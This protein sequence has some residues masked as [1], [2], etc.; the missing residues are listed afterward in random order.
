MTGCRFLLAGVA[1]LV[2]SATATA[3]GATEIINFDDLHPPNPRF[4]EIRIPAGYKGLTWSDEF[5]ALDTAN[6]PEASGFQNS[7]VSSPNVAFNGSADPVSFSSASDITVNSMYLGAGWDNDLTVT[8][9]GKEH[10]VPVDTTSVIVD[11]VG[12]LFVDLGWKDIDEVDFSTSGGVSAGY[13]YGL[14]FKIFTL[15]DLSVT[16]AVVPEPAT[17]AM[18]L[19]G[20]GGIGA[21]LRTRRRALRTAPSV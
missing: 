3:A 1:A 4:T 7:V 20:F 14:E 12:P 6:Y 19:A 8:I 10:G 13:D 21:L 18:L 2:L 11:T 17:W 16:G 5:I 9:V 15:D